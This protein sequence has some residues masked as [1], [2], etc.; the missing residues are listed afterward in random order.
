MYL[1]REKDYEKEDSYEERY[2]EYRSVRDMV[3]Y[4]SKEVETNTL[5]SKG[6]ELHIYLRDGL[7]ILGINL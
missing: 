5:E 7:L 1:G 2:L 4:Y 6:K 3:G